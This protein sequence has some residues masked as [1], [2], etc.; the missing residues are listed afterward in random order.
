MSI[1]TK[2]IVNADAEARYLS[3]GELDRIK[4][5]V[6]S[7][8]RRLR[9]AQTLTDNRERIVKQAGDQLFQ[10]RPDVV[11]PGGNAYGQEMT[12]TCLRDMDYY[13][14]LITYGVVAG[15]VTPIEEIGVV[16]V[17]EMYKSLGT[18]IEA[19]A[20]SVRAMKNVATSMMSS[21]DASEAGSYFDYLV[22]AMQ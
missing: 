6:T 3:P 18:P 19:V 9:I 13:L 10:K 7:G 14:R 12:A 11:S 5:F 20:E 22:G 16:G 1:V 8:E 21:E 4:S 17:R 2:S 15:D